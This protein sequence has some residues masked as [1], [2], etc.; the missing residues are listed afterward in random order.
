MVAEENVIVSL[1]DG[2]SDMINIKDEDITL[3]SPDEAVGLYDAFGTPEFD[4]L[5]LKYEKSRSLK[6]KKKIDKVPTP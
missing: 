3:F 2:V 5:Y 4:D 6:F 1:V